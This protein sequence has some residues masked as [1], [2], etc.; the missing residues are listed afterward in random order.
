[1]NE[2]EKER[3]EEEITEYIRL[4][5]ALKTNTHIIISQQQE[6]HPKTSLH[7]LTAYFCKSL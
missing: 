7:K 1:M 4:I 3:T 5:E 6:Q 2:Q